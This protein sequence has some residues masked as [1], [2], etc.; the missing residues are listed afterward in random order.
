MGFAARFSCAISPKSSYAKGETGVGLAAKKR[1][2][3]DT[4]EGFKVLTYLETRNIGEVYQLTV[5]PLLHSS[6]LK[7]KNIFS[8]SNALDVFEQTVNETLADLCRL[9]RDIEAVKIKDS[10]VE[11]F[12][13]IEPIL[14]QITKLELQFYQFKCFESIVDI[15]PKGVRATE[16]KTYFK[17]MMENNGC[18]NIRKYNGKLSEQTGHS[19]SLI[20]ILTSS[21]EDKL[22]Q[23]PISKEYVIRLGNDCADMNG[24]IE[25]SDMP[26]FLRGIVTGKT[27]RLCGAFTENTTFLD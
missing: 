17:E 15:D 23:E 3:D 16:I 11:S 22:H 9:S 13:N 7:L 10:I 12:P 1:L 8:N 6:I 2:F 4:N 24:R 5:V 18:Y 20:D 27:L 19:Q 25:L 14:M 21:F 26:Q